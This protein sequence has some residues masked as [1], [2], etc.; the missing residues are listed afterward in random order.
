MAFVPP[1]PQGA[2]EWAQARMQ[3]FFLTVP[4]PPALAAGPP[5]AVPP[6]AQAQGIPFAQ[7][8]HSSAPA[9]EKKQDE[10]SGL[11]TYELNQTLI[12]CGLNYTEEP[13]S[14]D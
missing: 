7:V 13:L 2:N 12:M 1:A 8:Q 10:S 11:T 5:T 14:N 6:Q 3:C 4:L 9:E